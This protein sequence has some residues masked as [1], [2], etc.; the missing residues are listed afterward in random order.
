M[1]S[2]ERDIFV[3]LLIFVVLSLG[4]LLACV[5]CLTFSVW[6]TF[7]CKFGGK[8]VVCESSGKSVIERVCVLFPL[9]LIL[10]K[11]FP[12]EEI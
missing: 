10:N 2:D 5:L 12:D 11:F 3:G 7:F 6:I 9:Y 8:P 4:A 1:G